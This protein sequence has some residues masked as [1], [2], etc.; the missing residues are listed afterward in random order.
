MDGDIIAAV[1]E[2]G[3]RDGMPDGIQSHNI[4]HESTLSDLSANEAGQDDGNSCASDNNWKDK[5]SL[6]K[7]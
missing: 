4:H 1:N 2:I 3:E 5:K 6:N 7:I